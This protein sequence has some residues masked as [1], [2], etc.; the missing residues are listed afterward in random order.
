MSVRKRK[1]AAPGCKKENISLHSLPK[2]ANTQREWL[3]FIFGK[4]PE[5]FSTTLVLCSAHFS[6]DSFCNLGLYQMGFSS[7]LVL[8]DGAVPSILKS[9]DSP[10]AVSK[11]YKP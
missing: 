4:V 5:D 6:E 7:K 11:T 8:K 9:P 10:Q 1:C 2:D 3:S